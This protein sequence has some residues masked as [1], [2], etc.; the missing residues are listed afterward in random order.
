LIRRNSNRAVP[1]TLGFI[2]ELEPH[3][4]EQGDDVAYTIHLPHPR[5]GYGYLLSW[6]RIVPF[7][8]PDRAADPGSAT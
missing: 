3:R 5:P 7:A 1:G 4:E 2:P 6:R 8:G